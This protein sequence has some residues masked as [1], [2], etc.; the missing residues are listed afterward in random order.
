MAEQ[1]GD[2]QCVDQGVNESFQ[3]VVELEQDLL[4]DEDSVLELESE[5]ESSRFSSSS[6]SSLT[7]SLSLHDNVTSTG[8]KSLWLLFRLFQS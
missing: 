2:H 8:K 5:E 4:E 3:E 7:G 6:S 1:S